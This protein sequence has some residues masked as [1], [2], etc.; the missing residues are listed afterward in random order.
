MEVTGSREFIIR[1]RGAVAWEWAVEG[2]LGG[3]VMV[4]KNGGG[5]REG[6]GS[7]GWR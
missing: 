7:L 3:K 4:G 2:G 1:T 6:L 5:S